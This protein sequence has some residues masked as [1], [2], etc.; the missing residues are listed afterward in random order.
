MARK[1]SR[2]PGPSNLDLEL[3]VDHLPL[4]ALLTGELGRITRVNEALMHLLGQEA[5][6]LVNY[7]LLDLIDNN[8]LMDAAKLFELLE[9][10]QRVERELSLR[11]EEGESLDLRWTGLVLGDHQLHF[12]DPHETGIEVPRP[13][14]RDLESESETARA[15]RLLKEDLNHLREK[16]RFNR[17]IQESMR[18]TLMVLD[19]GDR[20]IT[21]NPAAEALLGL[22]LENVE[23]A[24]FFSLDL[25]V[26]F[27][28]LAE[29]LRRVR[30]TRETMYVEG[31]E[32]TQAS[33]GPGFLA[34]TYVPLEDD[35]G[36]VVGII[37]LGEDITQ[38]ME[39]E[40]QLEE[41]AE[42]LSR[43]NQELEDFT[44]VVS[45]DLKEPLRSISAFSSFLLED[46]SNDLDDK[47]KEYLEILIR[48]SERMRQLIEDLLELS[49]IGRI[50]DP[51]GWVDTNLLLKEVIEDLTGAIADKQ[52]EMRI[53]PELPAIF[54][55][56]VRVRQ[57]FANLISNGLKF[58]MGKKPQIE[59][60]FIP[61]TRSNTFYVRDN[62][63]GIDPRYHEKIFQIF[64]RLGPRD[65]VE[66][67]GAGLTICR[68]I[69]E[70]MGGKLWLESE[71]DQGATFYFALPRGAEKEKEV[72]P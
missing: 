34:F 12:F 68:K 56:S 52:A 25:P 16:D 29:G 4:P 5:S 27:E 47:G 21:L 8:Q 13:V 42:E 41:K 39:L 31:L 67:T 32:Y 35:Y 66:G 53:E 50:Q 19:D 3:L 38:R 24:N 65:E 23:G 60:G 43:S 62:G 22:K 1:T 64:Q 20:L 11:R 14:M 36:K 15:N 46:Y 71:V 51:L 54:G 10:E 58:N 59:V 72:H 61:G 7:T 57:L 45:H 49:R 40:M 70:G 44:Y 6:E 28:G 33:G 18:A 9:T 48:S 26:Q 55:E 30:E 17:S 69:V 37:A 63:P 2:A